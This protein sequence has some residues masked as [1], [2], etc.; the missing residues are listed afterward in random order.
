MPTEHREAAE[1]A[2]PKSIAVDMERDIATA[3]D[4]ANAILAVA[5]TLERDDEACTSMER[6]TY[7]IM[8]KTDTF[9][10]QRLRAAGQDRR[11]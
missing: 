9:E 7:I 10:L 2:D 3:R 4:M 8:E 1:H 6:L 11:S 5:A